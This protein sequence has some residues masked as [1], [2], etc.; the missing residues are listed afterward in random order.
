MKVGLLEAGTYPAATPG[1]DQGYGQL[2]VSL[3]AGQSLSF[4]TY[5]LF[6]GKFPESAEAC[7]AWLITGSKLGAYD[8][9]PLIE[10]LEAL[11]RDIVATNRPLLGVCFGHQIIAQA[12][13]GRVEKWAG[14]W[15]LGATSY[16]TDAGPVRLHAFHQ[17]Q[18]VAMP[19]GAKLTASHP[20]CVNAGFRIGDTVLTYQA[21]PEFTNPVF[22][23]MIDKRRNVLPP[24]LVATATSDGAPALD[25]DAVVAE[26]VA[27]LKK[28]P[29]HG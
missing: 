3:L 23:K 24:E 9:D 12:L 4:E 2:F 19:D 8:D 29:V 17:D 20:G 25:T 27:H 15:N 22:T 28:E 26:M 10:P 1:G 7:D 18:V 21:H 5:P 11:T 14:G 13:G 6:E 16:E